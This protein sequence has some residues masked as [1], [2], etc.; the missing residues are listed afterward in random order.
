MCLEFAIANTSKGFSR[1][2]AV[3]Q[4]LSGLASD[5]SVTFRPSLRPLGGFTPWSQRDQATSQT[6]P[7]LLLRSLSASSVNPHPA[8]LL[9]PFVLTT[10]PDVFCFSMSRICQGSAKSTQNFGCLSLLL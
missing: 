1:V 10:R 3:T 7:P 6:E 8:T 4:G 5:F 2:N 9:S